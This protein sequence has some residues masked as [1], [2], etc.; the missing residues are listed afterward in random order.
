MFIT[1]TVAEG[2]TDVSNATVGG[3]LDV[4]TSMDDPDYVDALVLAIR[5]RCD[6]VADRTIATLVV[7]HRSHLA[8]K[9]VRDAE[10]NRS[11]D[12]LP[13]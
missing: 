10:R 5:A 8:A 4:V 11:H 13:I 1:A 12:E 3:S 2:Y 9:A 6:E 7:Q